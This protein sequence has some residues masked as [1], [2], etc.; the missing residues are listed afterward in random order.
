[1]TLTWFKIENTK[2][3]TYTHKNT[4]KQGILTTMLNYIILSLI[5]Q[6]SRVFFESFFGKVKQQLDS[7]NNFQSVEQY[8]SFITLYFKKISLI[9]T[10][11]KFA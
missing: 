3:N 7:F 10:A 4:H 6:T 2:Q 1:M 9:L 8:S 11:Q 5:V